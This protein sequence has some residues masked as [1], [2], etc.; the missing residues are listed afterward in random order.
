M[1]IQIKG[2]YRQL[3]IFLVI[4]IVI[5]L[6]IWFFPCGIAPS[7]TAC[8]V[9]RDFVTGLG[10]IY[11]IAI[12]MAFVSSIVAFFIRKVAATQAKK[13]H[14]EEATSEVYIKVHGYLLAG[15]FVILSIGLLVMA[16]YR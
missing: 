1:K 13:A 10:R 14:S 12:P 3:C 8:K 2:K 16:F 11:M 6:M 4:A 15:F 5:H 7:S 9:S